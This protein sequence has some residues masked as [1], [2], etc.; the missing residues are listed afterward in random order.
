MRKSE[1]GWKQE[2]NIKDKKLHLKIGEICW[3]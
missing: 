3:K 2:K 1:I